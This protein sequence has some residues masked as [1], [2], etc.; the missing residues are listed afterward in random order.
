[1]AR[2]N[3]DSAVRIYREAQCGRLRNEVAGS[4]IR[5]NVSRSRF[6]MD[7]ARTLNIERLNY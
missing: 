3:P 5:F 1:M 7:S 2:L 6:K 4:M